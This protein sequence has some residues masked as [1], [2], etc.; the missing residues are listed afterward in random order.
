[1]AAEPGLFTLASR[2]SG[3][4]VVARPDGVDGEDET[5]EVNVAG[6]LR[7]AGNAIVPQVGAAFVTAFEESVQELKTKG[8]GR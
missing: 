3:R 7:G 5:R 6:A 8:D 1:M 2:V 4:V